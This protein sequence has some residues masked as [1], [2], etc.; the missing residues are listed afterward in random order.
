MTTQQADV[1]V[2]RDDTHHRYEAHLD[3]RLAGYLDYR[4]RD[5]ELVLIHTETL[6]GF[7]GR[8]VATALAR[9]AMDDV[10]SR[11]RRA[12]VLCPFLRSWL[13]KNPQYHDIVSHAR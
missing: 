1:V 6:E 4:E 8:G 2:R 12:V 9:F 10:R 7:Q 13:T 11:G 5:D 3:D